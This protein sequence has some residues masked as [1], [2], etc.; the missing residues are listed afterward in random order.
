MNLGELLAELRSGMLN[1]RSDR[2]SGTSDY[3]WTDATL[4][5]YINEAHRRFASR[6]FCI[7]DG[8]TAE[9]TLVTLEE[10]IDTYTLHPSILAVK[11]A[12]LTTAS[13]DLAR[14]GHPFLA[15]YR[16]PTEMWLDPESFTSSDPGA[17]LAFSTD[18]EIG[19]DDY[20]SRSAV[21]LR[22]YPVPDAATTGAQ[23]RLRVV[24]RPLDD[25]TV[26]NS[27]AYPEIPEDHHLEMLDWAAYLALRIVDDDAG[28]PRRAAEFRA[29]F[30]EH[31]R[32]ARNMVLRKLQQPMPW[33]FGRSGFS[34]E[35]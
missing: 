12:K 10:G 25:F 4:V 5:R 23:I 33:G 34:W 26:S 9:V 30:E 19:E 20:G 29:S 18:E 13:I 21:V 35:H 28:S 17:P 31:V 8:S 3:L 16:A 24:R 27:G 6:S 14:V 32:L 7:Q 15:A 1:D 22:V 2:A 11:S